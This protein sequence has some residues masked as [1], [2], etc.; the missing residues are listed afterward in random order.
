[1]KKYF[2]S[3][4]IVLTAVIQFSFNKN[5]K[6]DL[7]ASIA[8]GQDIYVA[9]CIS[10][11]QEQGEGIE[12]VYPPL[13]KSDY[14]MADKNRSIKQIINGVSGEMKVNGKTYNS[15]MPAFDLSD[16]Q[17]SDV[18]NYIRNSWGNKGAAVTPAEVASARK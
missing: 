1:M 6:F 10:C 5:Q 3:T 11:H 15:E 14:L 8:R 7:K 4:F 17:V 16:E 9:Q 12:D 13:A 18:L 2:L